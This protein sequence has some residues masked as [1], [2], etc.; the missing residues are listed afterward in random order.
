LQEK[1]AKRYPAYI[2]RI[3]LLRTPAL[4]IAHIQKRQSGAFAA[5]KKKYMIP[6]NAERIFIELP[7]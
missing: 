4:N 5:W 7:G 6:L 2:L 3:T 1:I